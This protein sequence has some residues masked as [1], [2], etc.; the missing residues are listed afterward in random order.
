[1]LLTEKTENNLWHRR[2]GHLNY[3]GMKILGLPL[4]KERCTICM[5]AKGT[6]CSFRPTPMPLKRAKTRSATPSVFSVKKSLLVT[7]SPTQNFGFFYFRV[8]GLIRHF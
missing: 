4:S 6:R 8:S 5:E 1:M 7:P 3:Q 2:M